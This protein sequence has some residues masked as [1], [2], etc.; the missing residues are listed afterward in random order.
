MYRAGMAK[1]RKLEPQA[2]EPLLGRF[3][4]LAVGATAPHPDL[5]PTGLGVSPRTE[6]RNTFL[7]T[8]VTRPAEDTFVFGLN[9]RDAHDAGDNED[10]YL[11]DRKTFEVTPYL[12]GTFERE[13]PEYAGHHRASKAY[14]RESPGTARDSSKPG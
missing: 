8:V 4:S 7:G 13:F 12:R 10:M 6:P 14:L 2:V 1:T 11:L 9:Y 5:F 3:A